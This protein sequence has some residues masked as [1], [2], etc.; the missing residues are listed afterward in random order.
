MEFEHLMSEVG[1]SSSMAQH[2]ALRAACPA[3]SSKGASA[4]TDN[5]KTPRGFISKGE[6]LFL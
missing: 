6:N 3:W 5:D 4:E 2:V 1:R